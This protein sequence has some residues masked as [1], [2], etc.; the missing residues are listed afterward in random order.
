MSPTKT[1]PSATSHPNQKKQP[2]THNPNHS[3]PSQLFRKCSKTTIVQ[4]IN[5]IVKTNLPIDPLAPSAIAQTAHPKI[6]QQH[7]STPNIDRLKAQ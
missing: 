5:K 3:P 7:R 2:P 6:N 4:A 1:A